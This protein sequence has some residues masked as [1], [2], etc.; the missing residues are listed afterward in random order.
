LLAASTVAA[1]DLPRW[2]A[3]ASVQLGYPG[4]YVQVG[5]NQYA[6]DRLTFHHDLGVDLLEILNLDVGYHLTPRDS[7]HAALQM[8]FL[9]GSTT[10]P[11]DVFFNGAKLQAGT[12]LN[13]A[14]N[15]P[16]FFRATATYERQ[17]LTIRDRATLSA[18][19]GLTFVYLNFVIHGTLAPDTPGRETKEDFQTQE[20]PIPLL[21]LRFDDPLTG[22]LGFFATLDGGY[23]PWVDSLRTEGGTVNLT[24]SQADATA[25]LSYTLSPSLSLKAACAYTYIFQHEKS[26]ED[27]NLFN[28]SS[29]GLLL[30][31]TYRF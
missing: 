6:G 13:T 9:D 15:F 29:V 26:H 1:D 12:T 18:S 10:L 27:D 8:F 17:L 25:G 31:A 19:A 30:G 2:Q 5:E 4:G 24:Q 7:F 3:A 14:T 28:L 21:G 11:T 20:L 23:L 22:Q 16:D